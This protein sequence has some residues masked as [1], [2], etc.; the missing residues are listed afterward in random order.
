VPVMYLNVPKGSW[1]RSMALIPSILEIVSKDISARKMA[2]LMA[3]CWSLPSIVNHWHLR[4]LFMV[5][6][7]LNFKHYCWD[8]P[9]N[10]FLFFFSSIGAP[11]VQT[12][13]RG[14]DRVWVKFP[15]CTYVLTNKWCD[16]FSFLF[17][18]FFFFRIFGVFWLI[19]FI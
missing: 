14:N 16:E 19:F 8:F 11:K 15:E 1:P 2:T 9:N 3:L 5:K 12:P 10:F 13:Y 4:N 7:S 18:R 17:E 6:K